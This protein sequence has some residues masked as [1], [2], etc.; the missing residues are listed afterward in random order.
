MIAI[1]EIDRGLFKKRLKECRK[2]KGLSREQLGKAAG[3]SGRA[4]GLYEHGERFP[5]I[6]TLLRLSEAL[7]VPPWWLAGCLN[8]KVWENSLQQD[9]LRKPGSAAAEL[10]AAAGGVDGDTVSAAVSEAGSIAAQEADEAKGLDAAGNSK[11][12]RIPAA[13]GTKRLPDGS[14]SII[15]PLQPYTKK[16]SQEIYYKYVTGENGA[17]KKVPFISPSKAYR[18]Y[19]EDCMPFLRAVSI[20]YPV[21][22]RAHYYMGTRKVADLTNLNEALHDILQNRGVITGDDCRI[23][24]GTDGSRVFYDKDFPR[25]EVLITRIEA[26][27]PAAA[28]A[29][30]QAKNREAK[31]RK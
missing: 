17:Q 29:A 11:R 10:S 4:V 23:V 20:D 25:T 16:N 8:G 24:A 26:T 2:D 7:F 5:G 9:D 28:A 6:E 30:G 18:Q 15:I 3:I 21:N 13:A 19:Q 1:I 27:F 22:I 14:Y 31:R 12:T